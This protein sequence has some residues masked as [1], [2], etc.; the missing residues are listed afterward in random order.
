[1][2]RSLLDTDT[3]SE[4]IR[5]RNASV[6]SKSDAY[7]S[8]FGKY[9]ISV[10]TVSEMIDGLRRKNRDAK[11]LQL[12][13]MLESE[14]HEVLPLGIDEAKLAGYIFGDLHRSGQS[15]GAADPFIAAIAIQA[16]IP[17]ITG[18]LEHYERIRGFGYSLTI[19]TWHEPKP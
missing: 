19:E 14:Q 9:T 10:M 17:L 18:N 16:G 7:L 3:F 1:M 4:V 8:V 5:G 2:V 15:I 6:Q 13:A 11:I 12:L